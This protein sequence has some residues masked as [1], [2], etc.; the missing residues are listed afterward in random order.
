MG[1]LEVPAAFALLGFE[2]IQFAALV[3]PDLFEVANG[4]G[5]GGG[6]EVIVAVAPESIEIIMFG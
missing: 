4:E 3:G 2:E 1:V 5:F 6:A